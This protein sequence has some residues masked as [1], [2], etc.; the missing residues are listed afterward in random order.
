[1]NMGVVATNQL[2]SSAV[3]WFGFGFRRVICVGG[4]CAQLSGK[5][6]RIGSIGTTQ[7]DEN[8][9]KIVQCPLRAPAM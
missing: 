2:K 7:K 5:M 6:Q 1:M 3:Q 9:N 8:F 4:S